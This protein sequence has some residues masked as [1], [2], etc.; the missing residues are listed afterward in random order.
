MAI[1]RANAQ[2]FARL[3]DLKGMRQLD[4]PFRRLKRVDRFLT[5]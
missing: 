1:D 4:P 2:A 3:A 5:I